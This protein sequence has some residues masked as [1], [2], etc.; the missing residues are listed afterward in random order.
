MTDAAGPLSLVEQTLKNTL[1]DCAAFRTWVGASGD[2]AQE[3][4]RN[5]IHRAALGPP[6]DL[7][8]YTKAELARK[9]PYVLFWDTP[10]FEIIADSDAGYEITGTLAVRFE[11]DVPEAIKNDPDEIDLRFK[12]I[13]GEILAELFAKRTEGGYLAVT[14]ISK[15]DMYNR[16][17]PGEAKTVGDVVW[18]DWAIGHSGI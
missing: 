11:W 8:E 14:A 9:R 1:G 7:A 2:D 3:Q 15:A 12:N 17:E 10:D 4:A 5:R 13:V 6:D 16:T 18:W